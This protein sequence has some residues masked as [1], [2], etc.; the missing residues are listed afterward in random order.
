MVTLDVRFGVCTN[1]SILLDI[2]SR[3]GAICQ[4]GIET[5]PGLFE[6]A[7]GPQVDQ[8]L[9]RKVEKGP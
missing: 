1:Q 9:G 4:G 2:C 6:Q 7:R 8:L 5:L 3:D